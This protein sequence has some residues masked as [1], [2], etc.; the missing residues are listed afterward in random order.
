MVTG[1]SQSLLSWRLVELE[2]VVWFKWW[3]LVVG[4]M[5][6]AGASVNGGGTGAVV[7]G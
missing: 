2:V 6:L 1:A 7:W 5:E 4:W 3:G